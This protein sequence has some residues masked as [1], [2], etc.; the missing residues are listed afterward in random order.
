MSTAQLVH[1]QAS[2]SLVSRGAIDVMPLALSVVPF[3]VV[4][5]LALDHAGLV[6]VPALVGTALLY[7]GSAQL[8]TLSVITA[9]GG[10]VGA[11]IAGAVINARLLLYSASHGHRF[12]HDQPTWFRWV[13]PLTTVDQTFALGAAAGHLH[14]AAFR[15]YW[16]TIGLVLGTVWL[17]AVALGMSVSGGLSA[18][19]SPMDVAAPATMVSLLVPYLPD[20]RLRRVALVAALAAMVGQAL[21]SGLGVAGAIFAGLVV[22][23]PGRGEVEA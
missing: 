2:P 23:G 16:T 1:D 22:A 17:A 9:G 11:V 8:A 7:A 14:G 21:P 6:G 20:R 4:V 3:G 19:P 18:G 5:G 12:R 15:R 13:A 10:V